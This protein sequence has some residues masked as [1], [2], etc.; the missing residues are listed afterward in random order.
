MQWVGHQQAA[1]ET[2][3]CCFKAAGTHVQSGARM[4]VLAYLH[5]EAQAL[6]VVCSGAAIAQHH[7]ATVPAH[8][9]KKATPGF[10]PGQLFSLVLSRAMIFAN[11]R[12]TPSRI[13]IGQ[14]CST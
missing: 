2:R 3:P 12:A 11:A 1:L 14:R 10:R 8:L 5:G 7:I 9:S 6:G 13:G 4:S